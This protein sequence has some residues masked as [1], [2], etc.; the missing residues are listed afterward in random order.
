M[1]E[2]APAVAQPDTPKP[3]T[4]PE[5]IKKLDAAPVASPSPVSESSVKP[6]TD[7]RLIRLL[8]G[9]EP[10]GAFWK[11]KT[12]T[13]IK[14]WADTAATRELK[15]M[16]K[17]V[18]YAGVNSPTLRA[19]YSFLDTPEEKTAFLQKHFGA[20]NVTKDSFG[21]DVVVINGQK[22]SFLP[23]G[24]Q[25][26]GPFVGEPG[27]KI[28]KWADLAG[29]VAPVAGMVVGSLAT[30]PVP[31]A[32][33]AG[34]AVGAAG[35]RGINKLIKEVMGD[36]LQTTPEISKD[37]AME[38]PKGAAAQ[39]G[40]EAIGIVGK[41]L[42]RGPFRE[43]SIFGPITKRG[44]EAFAK[45]QTEVA[46]ARAEGL[47]P[48]VG[49]YS[50]NASFTQRVQNAGF[51]LFGDDTTIKNRPVIE[52]GAAKLTG[53]GIKN[54]TDAAEAANRAIEARTNQIVKTYQ[55]VADAA[56]VDAETLLKGAEASITSRV[57]EP[58]GELAYHAGADIQAA[59][60][61][62]TSKAA[63][64]YGPVDALAGKPV[65]PYA[66]VKGMMKQI[67]DEMPQ[68]ASGQPAFVSPELKRFASEIAAL[69]DFG[70]FQ[71]MQVVRTTLRDY[72]AVQ[73]LNAGLSERQ[74]G[75]LAMAADDAF[76]DAQSELITRVT[77]P[78]PPPMPEFKAKWEMENRGREQAASEP[79]LVLETRT[80]TPGVEEAKTALREGDKFYREGIQK[81]HDLSTLAMVKD[82]SQSGFVEP[83]KVASRLAMP[84]QNDKLLRIKELVTPSTFGEIGAQKWS[85]MLDKSRDAMTGNVSGKTL[86]RQ[87]KQMGPVLETLY[88]K[89][90]AGRMVSY[91]EHLAALNGDF[92]AAALEPGRLSSVIKDAIMKKEASDAIM[93][94]G[95]VKALQ[96][97][98]PQSLTAVKWLTEPEHRLALRQTL[99][100]FGK[101][102]AEAKNIKEYLARRILTSMEV[103]ATRG[104]EK[105]GTTELMGEP[106]LKELDRYGKPYLSEVFGKDWT[107]AAYK[108]ANN[109]EVATRKNPTDSGGLIAAQLGLHWIRHLGEIGKYFTAG[110]ALTRPSVITYLSKGFGKEGG[111]M[112]FMQKALGTGTKIGLAY[113]A[114]EMPKKT[115]DYTS[116]I[117]THAQSQFGNM[118]NSTGVRP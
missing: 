109:V 36:N 34:S 14:D 72:S 64:I 110:E 16:D 40:G 99:D 46:G 20:K 90:E 26:Q 21:R 52:A 112:D 103:P 4:D 5:L 51:R 3:V 74:A 84:G 68:T 75:R 60:T 43:G 81:F 87:L 66:G 62:F 85:Q 107:D 94:R 65:V 79:P 108:F 33:I 69:P 89:A 93:S 67:L 91:A 39:A 77:A 23:R 95:F 58:S 55:A 35:G 86:A 18:D 30:A 96:S 83:E 8:D 6:V 115:A 61:A 22:V 80:V 97:D 38:I 12:S 118:I 102:S 63:E 29:D 9:A 15:Q 70:T 2:N 31:G 105:Y 28:S 114:E 1:S 78:T 10:A 44:K 24:N 27:S 37:I 82:A 32:S 117:A 100:V 50:P 53:G 106:L 116:G 19:E 111:V 59:K 76:N 48:K 42:L 49:T 101:D 92:D 54:T 47:I 104:A 11:D 41:S 17:G 71:Q 98:G 73:A 113:E 56:K 45:A 13:K 88:G 25:P 7:P 57:G